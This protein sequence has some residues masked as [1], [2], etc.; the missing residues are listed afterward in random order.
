MRSGYGASGPPSG[1]TIRGRPSVTPV[2]LV[3]GV[4]AIF[5]GTLNKMC[6]AA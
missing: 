2:E 1:P 5:R 3:F 6:V 4:S